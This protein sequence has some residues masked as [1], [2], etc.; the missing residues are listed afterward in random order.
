MK[1]RPAWTLALGA[2]LIYAATGG[3]RIVGS[4]EVTMLELSRALLHGRIQVPEGATMPGRGGHAYTKNSAG[5]A[6]AALPLAALAAVVSRA[7]PAARRELAERAVVSFFNAIVTAVLLGVFYSTARSLGV[8]GSAAMAGALLLGFTTPLWVYAKSFMAEPLE[9][10]GLLLALGGAARARIGGRGASLQ[11]AAG[12]LI[13][14]CSKLGVLPIAIAA[15]FPIAGA[16][17]RSWR[18]PLLAFALALAAHAAYDVARFGTAFE[19]GYGAQATPAAYSTPLWVGLYG[20]LLSSGKGVMWFA[21]ALWLVPAGWAAMRAAAGRAKATALA[22]LLMSAVALLLYGRFQHWAGD[23]SFGPRYLVPVMPAAF[24]LVAFA[25]ERASAWRRAASAVLGA[26]GLLVTI[27]GVA[28]Y[29]GAQMRDAGDYPYTLPLDH[30]HFMESSHFNPRFSPI[31]GH[32]SMLRRNLD[33]AMHGRSPHITVA[34]GAGA[35]VTANQGLEAHAGTG[36][37]ASGA[38][39]ER[40]G[41]GEQDQRALLNGFDFWWTYASYAGLPGAPLALMA[42][43]LFACGV[44]SLWAARRAAGSE[45]G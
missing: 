19:T 24:L 38:G 20:L 39:G 16:P 34:S 17:R 6:V 13:S 41:V 2:F 23:G 12:V 1:L 5:Q 29:F 18:W 10:L 32:W 35:G 33:L 42:L 15:V 28:I 3:G 30:P 22:V 25:L 31:L 37:G 26:A 43:A 45:T 9:A 27:G 11:T 40:V 8:S 21:P 14:V 4:D 44:T 7:V 36:P